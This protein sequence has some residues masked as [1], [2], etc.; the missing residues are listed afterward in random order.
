MCLPRG[1]YRMPGAWGCD[2]G[3]CDMSFRRFISKKE[4]QERLAEYRDQLKKELEGVEE[5]IADIKKG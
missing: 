5:Y 4:E 1:S 3:C 2:C